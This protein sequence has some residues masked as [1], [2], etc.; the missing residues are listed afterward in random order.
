MIGK[1]PII[2]PGE[3]YKQRHPL[4]PSGVMVGSAFGRRPGISFE[5]DIP[6]LSHSPTTTNDELMLS[7][8]LYII[9]YLLALIGGMTLCIA[10]IS[11]FFLQEITQW[12]PFFLS[13][14]LSLFVG[15]GFI[16]GFNSTELNN[17][18]TREI[19]LLTFLAWLTISIF[20]SLPFVFSNL[21]LSFTD[22]LFE[23]ASAI[24]TTGATVLTNL[25]TYPKTILL[26]RA[27][28]DGGI[29]IVI[30]I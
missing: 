9:G 6:A 7:G 26:W 25:N 23:T 14:A 29:G 30:I 24:T 17:V 3:G 19:F 8:L 27:L 16:L 20:A 11:Y 10:G 13:A 4:S 15:G 21:D 2:K 22:A 5:V 12:I 18:R 1:Q 28:L